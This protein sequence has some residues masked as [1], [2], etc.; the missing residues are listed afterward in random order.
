VGLTAGGLAGGDVIAGGN[1]VNSITLGALSVSANGATLNRN[2]PWI[3][4]VSATGTPVW[5]HTFATAAPGADVMGVA[6]TS[7]GGFVALGAF[8]DSIDFGSGMTLSAAGYSTFLA[9]FDSDGTATAARIFANGSNVH[10]LGL[11]A[12]A[13]GNVYCGGSYQSLVLDGVTRTSASSYDLFALS[14]DANLTVRWV[15]TVANGLAEGWS[16]STNGHMMIAAPDSTIDW[17]SGTAESGS[18][19]ELDMNGNL[20]WSRGFPSGTDSMRATAVTSDGSGG[21]YVG[22]YCA[23]SPTL[24]SVTLSCGADGHFMAHV[25]QSDVLWAKSVSGLLASDAVVAPDGV[26]TL[27]GYLTATSLDGY[28]FSQTSAFRD[29]F[30]AQ[31]DPATGSLGR[32]LQLRNVRASSAE[33]DPMSADVSAPMRPVVLSS[34]ERF[35]TRSTSAPTRHSWARAARPASRLWP[36]GSQLS[37]SELGDDR[38]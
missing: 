16:V 4:R 12:D 11:R 7:D 19:A 32:V 28:S 36:A 34:A 25:T 5:L 6:G 10:F 29:R 22:G 3:A 14:L 37:R 2:S 8:Y 35:A 1:F 13:S 24:G 23:G 9:H 21:A 15:T 20:V 18:F 31:L 38:G 30:I 27:G 33:S 17:G 26:L